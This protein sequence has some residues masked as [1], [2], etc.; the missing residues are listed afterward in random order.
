VRKILSRQELTDAWTN[1]HK[2]SCA[3]YWITLDSKMRVESQTKSN[4]VPKLIRFEG[5]IDQYVAKLNEYCYG[6]RF[7]RREPNARL[8]CVVSYEIGKEDGLIHA[9][10]LAGHDGSTNRS[11]DQVERFT[12]RKWQNFYDFSG[13]DQC[14]FV[15]SIGNPHD[16][17]WYMTKQSEELQKRFGLFNVT[18][19]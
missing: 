15:E 18:V 8:T 13:S 12:Y 6:A 10:I 3:G 7:L 16:R 14:L 17:I 1:F 2:K 5:E 19:H 11:V 9:H 4:V